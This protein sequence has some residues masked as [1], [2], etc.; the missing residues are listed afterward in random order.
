MQS[1]NWLSASFFERILTYGLP[2]M[3]LDPT[4]YFTN[5]GIICSLWSYLEY[6][7]SNIIWNL[8]SLDKEIGNIVTGGRDILPKINM[9]IALAD[10][11]NADRELRCALVDVRKQLQSGL[12]D[13]RNA[14]VHGVYSSNETALKPR[15]ETHRG[16]G[17]GQAKDVDVAELE[18]V[19]RDIQKAI[20]TL[21]PSCE[22]LGIN[23]H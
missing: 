2:H 11:L 12:Q 8:L 15:R 19:V 4:R 22:R 23:I 14:A 20:D 6:I 16:K 10:R 17:S 7:L 3:I 1:I 13:Q 5:T 21:L 18:A 9:A